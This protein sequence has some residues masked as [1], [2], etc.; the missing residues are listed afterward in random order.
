MPQIMPPLELSAA[1][2]PDNAADNAAFNQVRYK[3][4][5]DTY[6]RMSGLSTLLLT[7][8]ITQR[9]FDEKNGVNFIELPLLEDSWNES[10]GKS[11]H[12]KGR[13]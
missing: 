3:R 8:N 1:F 10:V 6:L 4:K 11:S 13:I 7:E 9:E 12:T 2:R 5:P